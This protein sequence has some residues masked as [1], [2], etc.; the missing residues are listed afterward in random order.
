MNE[1]KSI[2]ASK[3]FWLNAI[4]GGLT[5]ADSVVGTGVLGPKTTASV[6]PVMAAVNIWLRTITTQ[7]VT[8]LP[9]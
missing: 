4:V 7:P 5:L 1:A 6:A 3:T 8:V 2:F 9:K